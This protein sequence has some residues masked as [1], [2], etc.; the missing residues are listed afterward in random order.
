VTGDDVLRQA[1]VWLNDPL[2]WR[3]PDGVPALV[4]EHLAMSAAAVALAAL[5]GGGGLGTI[6]VTGFAPRDRKSGG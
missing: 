5:V 3:G 4:A 2:N 1:F 6:V